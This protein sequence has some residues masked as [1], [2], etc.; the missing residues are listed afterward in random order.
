MVGLG[1]GFGIGFGIIS[2]NV[3]VD[4]KVSIGVNSGRVGLDQ[5]SSGQV[6][7]KKSR[8]ILMELARCFMGSIEDTHE[9][10]STT[11]VSLETIWYSRFLGSWAGPGRFWV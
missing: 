7:A 8:C 11:P 2:V 4:I 5:V 9:R 1:K 10:L 3:R 6:K